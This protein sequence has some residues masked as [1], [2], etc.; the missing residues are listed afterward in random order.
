[1]PLRRRCGRGWRRRDVSLPSAAWGRSC[2]CWACCCCSCCGDG[3][4]NRNW[5]LLWG[6]GLLLA[7]S[8]FAG[9]CQPSPARPA[10][11]ESHPTYPL[12]PTGTAEPIV[13]TRTPGGG[14]AGSAVPGGGEIAPTLFPLSTTADWQGDPRWG[15]GVAVGP[16]SRY[17]V[18]ALGLGWYL[19]WTIWSDDGAPQGVDFVPMIRLRD[20][21][22]FPDAAAI[23]DVARANPASL[24]LVGNEP[25]V[26]WQDN[27]TPD[28]YAALY[29]QAY[30]AIKAA[31]PTARVAIGGVS[32]PTPLRLRYLDQVL[33]CYRQQFAGE[34]PVDVWNVHNFILREERDSWG[35][36]IPPGFA[37]E[38]GMLYEIDDSDDLAIFARQIVDFRR[39]MAERG[40]RDRPLVVSEYGIL[41]PEDYGFPPQRVVA[42]I[43]GSFDF[44]LAAADPALGYPAD[45]DRLVQRWC[46]YS[47]ADVTYPTG[48]LF[49]P[50]T[51]EMTA[52]GVGWVDGVQAR[53][54]R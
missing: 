7:L 17:G 46:W 51:G 22:L 37:D 49:D 39:W 11:V 18:S 14:A 9:A 24:W 34:M 43:G 21:V 6:S 5:G 13:P 48:N 42:F 3:V 28:A 29:H 45:D 54:E 26:R 27:V 36:D 30:T 35:V 33:A 4:R 19:N 44:F 32:Q 15:V 50:Q 2:P 41:M 40:Y 1:M 16:L 20:G 8:L 12:P 53:W 25:D 23:A 10:V 31:D 52:V 47:L 38:A